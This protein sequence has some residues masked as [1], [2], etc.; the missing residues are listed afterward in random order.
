MSSRRSA[1]IVAIDKFN[2]FRDLL[3]DALEFGLDVDKFCDWLMDKFK[4]FVAIQFDEKRREFGE[5]MPKKIA[6]KVDLAKDNGQLIADWK[7]A[8]DQ[9]ETLKSVEQQLRVKLVELFFKAEKLEG[10]E[11]VDIGFDWKL[12]SVKSLNITATNDNNEVNALL[13]ALNQVDHATAVGL[14]NWIP[15]VKTKAYRDLCE[16]AEKYPKLKTLMTAAITVKPG[17]PQL[18]LVPP[19]PPEIKIEENVP[20]PDSGTLTTD[21]T[22]IKW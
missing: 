15:D 16:L 4:E 20:M 11:S 7:A 19:P 21:G 2:A 22:N 10:T 14:I 8:H 5:D 1:S 6:A 3:E 18:Q 12:K 9:L 13:E 17:M